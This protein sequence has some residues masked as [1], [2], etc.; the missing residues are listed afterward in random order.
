MQELIEF[1]FQKQTIR[2]VVINGEVHWIAKDVCAVLDIA[3]QYYAL[4]KLDNDEKGSVKIQTPGGRQNMVTVIES[5]L[6]ALILGASKSS[7]KA[8]RRWVTHRVLPQIRKT[9]TYEH[10]APIS[11]PMPEENVV[12][13]PD[14][15]NPAAAARAW[16]DMYEAKQSAETKL[17]EAQPKIEVYDAITNSDNTVDMGEVARLISVPGKVIGRNNLFAL[18]RQEKILMPDNQPYQNYV[19]SGY[20]RIIMMD[21]KIPSGET[22]WKPKTLVYPKGLAYIKKVVERDRVKITEMAIM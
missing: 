9:G 11:V 12:A 13:L 8:F 15:S 7:A 6:Y 21:Y 3:D 10:L 2:T 4:E 1:T 19:D 22:R 18:L 20:F 17:I 14:F 16:A 5:G